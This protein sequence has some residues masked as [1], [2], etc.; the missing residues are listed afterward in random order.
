MAQEALNSW[1][2]FRSVLDGIQ[3]MIKIL[4]RDYKI[5]YANRSAQEY[6]GK[7]L[8]ELIGRHC[9]QEYHQSPLPPEHCVTMDTYQTG[10]PQNSA[11]TTLEPDGL[12]RHW[13]ISTFPLK[14]D[15][16]NVK[17]IIEIVKDIT[18]RKILR[19]QLVEA[20]R[21]A[22]LG[23]LAAGIA[24]ELRNPLVA[25]GS[26]TQLL[27]EDTDENDPR[28]GDIQ[29]LIREIKRLDKFIHEFLDF[30]APK[31]PH[32]S[33][34]DL[35]D[36]IEDTLVLLDKQ[37]SSNKIK[38]IKKFP[39]NVPK[40]LLDKD[41]IKQVF[42]NI[43]V[44]AMEAMPDG[45]ELGITVTAAPPGVY[46][47]STKDIKGKSLSSAKGVVIEFRDTG[48]GIPPDKLK[49]IFDPFFSYGKKGTGLG[50]SICHKIVQ[51]HLGRIEVESRVNQGTRVKIWLPV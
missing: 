29:T 38:I 4:D 41:Q 3:D 36:L 17:Y 10:A 14:D 35:A 6:L 32:P 30:S 13:E 20:E 16:G 33:L 25:I 49:K 51:S 45:G 2:F 8:E 28:K 47:Q 27:D 15:E 9:Y 12:E 43:I 31:G 26:I 44:N 24:H 7:P 50:L 48:C 22:S 18:E 21:L 11:F 42:L 37:I 23:H 34:C 39:K 19:Y 40:L 46:D 5:I 1:D